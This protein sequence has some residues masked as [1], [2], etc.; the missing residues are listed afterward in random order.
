[1][2]R[3]TTSTTTGKPTSTTHTSITTRYKPHH[4]YNTWYTTNI[5]TKRFKYLSGNGCCQFS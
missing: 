3:T 5:N 4:N 1:M 2:K